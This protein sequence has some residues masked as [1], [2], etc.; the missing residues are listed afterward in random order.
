MV[1]DINFFIF[2]VL[3]QIEEGIQAFN[4]EQ[5]DTIKT[6]IV[7][8]RMPESVDFKISI[9][10]PKLNVRAELELIIYQEMFL[11]EL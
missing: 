2:K 6:N 7:Q 11:K 4:V 1:E 3:S 5:K 8:A 10:D 9:N